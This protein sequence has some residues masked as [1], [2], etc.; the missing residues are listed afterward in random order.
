M[1]AAYCIIKKGS[2]ILAVTRESNMEDLGFPGGQ[3]ELGERPEDGAIR[4]LYEETGLIGS[5]PRLIFVDNSQEQG[6]VLYTY[7][8]DD[9]SGSLRPSSEGT[10]MWVDP[11]DFITNKCRHADYNKKVLKFLRLL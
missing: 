6:L 7:E 9:W 2:K 8:V 1:I 11:E 5:D 3:V 4:E 10:P